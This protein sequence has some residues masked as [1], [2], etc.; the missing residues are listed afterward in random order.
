MHNGVI[1]VRRSRG[2]VDG[3]VETVRAAES[4]ARDVMALEVAP[5]VFNGVPLGRIRLADTWT[6]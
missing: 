2:L 6:W 3:L 1:F 5:G 4:A